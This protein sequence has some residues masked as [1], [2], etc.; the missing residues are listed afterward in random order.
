VAIAHAP[1]CP[2]YIFNK[3]STEFLYFSAQ[4]P[5]GETYSGHSGVRSA[6]PLTQEEC[7]LQDKFLATPA[8]ELDVTFA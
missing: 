1:R 3:N 2:K 5:A 6:P 7:P 8:Y 4:N